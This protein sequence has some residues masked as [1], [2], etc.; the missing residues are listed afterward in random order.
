LRAVI[1]P[2]STESITPLNLED[3][4]S[5]VLPRYSW[6]HYESLDDLFHGTGVRVRFLDHHLEIM[7]PISESHEERKIH[8]SCLVETWCLDRDV[9]LFGRR[10]ATNGVENFPFFWKLSTCLRAAGCAV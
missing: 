2:A 4:T 5:L 9:E 1:G 7:A 3:Q 8:V 10:S 6:A